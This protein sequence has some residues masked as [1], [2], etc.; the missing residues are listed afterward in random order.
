MAMKWLSP[1]GLTRLLADYYPLNAAQVRGW[2]E[3]GRIPPEF[4]KRAPSL[5][6]RGQWR[7]SVKGLDTILRDLLDLSTTEMTQIYTHIGLTHGEV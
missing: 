2:C 6:A 4:V 5:K 1:P 3:E 7:I